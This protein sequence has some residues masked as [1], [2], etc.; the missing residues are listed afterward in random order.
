MILRSTLSFHS[1]CAMCQ[2]DNLQR[3]MLRRG[4]TDEMRTPVPINPRD[5][6]KRRIY[7]KEI[8]PMEGNNSWGLDGPVAE[9]PQAYGLIE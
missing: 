4:Q 5:P 9:Y 3:S 7:I 6:N 2:N 8:N 1:S